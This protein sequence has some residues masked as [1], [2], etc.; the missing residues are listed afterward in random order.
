MT[1]EQ[2]EEYRQ[3]LSNILGSAA[4]EESKTVPPVTRMRKVDDHIMHF[5]C[6]C[7]AV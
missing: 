3:H 2:K 4:K 1:D 5:V 6:I 7:F